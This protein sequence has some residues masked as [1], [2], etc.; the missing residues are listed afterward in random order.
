MAQDQQLSEWV[1]HKLLHELKEGIYRDAVKIP[2]EVEIAETLGVSR[3][4]LRDALSKLE[5]E[6]FIS[7]RQGRGTMVNRHVLSVATRMDIEEEF[8]SMIKTAGKKPQ[9]ESCEAK[10]ISA[11]AETA[12][13]L[14]IQT[15]APIYQVTRLI[16]A[17][18]IPAIYC[19]DYF[20]VFLIS[21]TE[22]DEKV[23]TGEPIFNFLQKFCNVTPYMDL[24]EVRAISAGSDIAEKLGVPVSSPVLFMNEVD[25]DFQ[26]NPVLNSLEYYRDGVL[27]HTVLRKI[28]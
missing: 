28:I 24:T 19:I 1:S 15:G 5:Q 27:H 10:I 21:E 3:T 9:T 14:K 17:D 7:R 12:D 13:A 25:Y 2:P 20:P 23:L 6:G 26:G 8:L 22:Y 16:S 11:P 4:I 18:G